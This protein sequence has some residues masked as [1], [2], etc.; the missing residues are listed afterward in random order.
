MKTILVAMHWQNGL[1]NL[2]FGKRKTKTFE[3]R[4][5]AFPRTF[6]IHYQRVIDRSARAKR[7]VP[8]YKLMALFTS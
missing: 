6:G 7:G 8:F 2:H 4:F 3:Q 1:A 5:I